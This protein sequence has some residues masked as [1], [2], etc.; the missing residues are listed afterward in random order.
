[1]SLTTSGTAS[2]IAPAL[3]TTFIPTAT[4][5]TENRLTMLANRAFEIWM[6]VPVPVPGTTFT[7]CYPSQFVTSYLQEAGGIT[8]AAFNPLVCP[9]NYSAV[10][11]YTSNYI[12]CCPSGY[13]L[14]QAT[15][16]PPSDR[17][18][19]GA[20]CYT[21]LTSG[22]AVPVTAY[23]SSGVTATT[24]FAA[25]VTNAQAYAYPIDGYAF[26]VAQ[27]KSITPTAAAASST[28]QTGSNPAA[29]YT[30]FADT[31]PVFTPSSLDAS[32]GDTVI[33]RFES[34]NHTITQ[35]T[36]DTP[37]QK[38]STDG[39]D[40]GYMAN[41]NSDVQPP[42]QISLNVT[43][44]APQ[45]FY[46]EQS[47]DC[48]N[49]MTF[50]LNPTTDQTAAEFR[51]AAMSQNG[52]LTTVS[53][54]SGTSNSVKIGVGVGVSVGA[55]AGIA[56]ALALFLIRRR[57]KSREVKEIGS[58]DVG[59]KSSA[60]DSKGYGRDERKWNDTSVHKHPP[61]PP[62]YEELHAISS[63]VEMEGSPP[64]ELMGS[65]MKGYHQ[66]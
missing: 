10:G 24:T 33:F 11:P 15:V 66:V 8:Q 49:G 59:N 13:S 43:S 38:L 50:A 62:K 37:C 2:L 64:A 23:G 6:N 9:V 29:T 47:G 3:T 26:G 5:C 27:V 53:K 32:I 42:P 20:T 14:A 55:L 22:V 41:I 39:L 56:G 28:S 31:N 7:D 57:R 63:P 61:V 40:S 4:T 65:S 60:Y 46:S 19:F 51:Q 12:A 17:P 30:I 58:P 1:M 48:G 35:S 45:W 52:T 54:E 21:P 18:A 25:T 16:D 36:F 34:G 44:K